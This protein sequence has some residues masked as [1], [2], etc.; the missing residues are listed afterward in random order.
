MPIDQVVE[1][2]NPALRGWVNYF[3]G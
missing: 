3:A 2:I 1:L